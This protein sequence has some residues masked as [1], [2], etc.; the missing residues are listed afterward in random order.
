M[1]LLKVKC[2]GFRYI[3]FNEVILLILKIAF[4]TLFCK[5][6][7][8]SNDKNNNIKARNE[9]ITKVIILKQQMNITRESRFLAG[10][11]KHFPFAIDFV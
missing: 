5:A 1:N 3:E 9:K 8:K 4:K 11:P 7:N 10:E 6:M 2:F